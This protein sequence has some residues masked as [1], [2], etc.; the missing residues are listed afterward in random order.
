MEYNIKKTIK[1]EAGQFV[2]TTNDLFIPTS[3]NTIRKNRVL[4]IIETGDNFIEFEEFYPVNG[5]SPTKFLSINHEI[6]NSPAEQTAFE[7][8]LSSIEYIWTPD[9]LEL[10]I[11]LEHWTRQHLENYIGFLQDRLLEAED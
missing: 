1:L 9:L 6:D 4:K 7:E 5:A 2:K 11:P 10:N 3:G 8:F